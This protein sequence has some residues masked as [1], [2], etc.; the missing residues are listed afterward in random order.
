MAILQNTGVR[1]YSHE[2]TQWLKY[3]LNVLT[4]A[5][6]E[7]LFSTCAILAQYMDKCATCYPSQETI[8]RRLKKD[9][10]STN[11]HIKQLEKLQLLELHKPTRRKVIYTGLYYESDKVTRGGLAH[12]A[13][14]WFEQS[15]DILIENDKASGISVIFALACCM[16]KYNKCHPSQ[17]TI[18]KI[19]GK[20]KRTVVRYIKDLE[21][22]NIIEIKKKKFG[23]NLYSGILKNTDINKT[24]ETSI[25]GGEET[26]EH[27]HDAM[28]TYD[29]RPNATSDAL[30]RPK[31]IDYIKRKYC[32]NTVQVENYSHLMKKIEKLEKTNEKQKQENEK[33]N[34]KLDLILKLISDESTAK[35]YQNTPGGENH[36]E[37][38]S[39]SKTETK[40]KTLTTQPITPTENTTLQDE[41][42]SK[43]IIHLTDEAVKFY[44]LFEALTPSQQTELTKE[45]Q[46][47]N[48][49]FQERK[50]IISKKQHEE[51]TKQIEDIKQIIKIK[52]PEYKYF[53]KV[54]VSTYINGNNSLQ[55]EV[56]TS[57][58]KDVLNN[59]YYL[60]SYL[61]QKLGVAV[62][63]VY[64]NKTYSPA[65]PSTQTIHGVN[66]E[67]ERLSQLETVYNPK[68]KKHYLLTEEQQKTKTQ[69]MEY[70]EEMHENPTALIYGT[71]GTGKTMLLNALL[72][73]IAHASS[74]L[75]KSFYA[76]I[77]N[78][79]TLY[80]DYLTEDPASK[81]KFFDKVKKYHFL[82]IDEIPQ[83]FTDAE[84]KV[85]SDLITYRHENKQRTF[86]IS[87]HNYKELTKN[88]TSKELRT[89]LDRVK[90]FTL[91]TPSMRQTANLTAIRNIS[92]V[93]A[94]L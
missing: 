31:E 53:D 48:K 13:R 4:Q 56:N 2:V 16:D 71:N 11:K 63:I 33:I 5:K 10:R 42:Q 58:D 70:I 73:E 45:K 86:L 72:K 40:T 41:N 24:E 9:R 84:K 91:E 88:G 17:E 64:R 27:T 14:A 78:F 59:N 3:S 12:N 39:K 51:L 85:F 25:E 89:V 28:Y 6:K 21:D 65:L 76:K 47:A 92:T 57:F 74:L 67:I 75:D 93:N 15:T 60:Q 54:N 66:E 22:L 83:H 1:G 62:S 19:T 20:G 94:I 38:A 68:S 30:N 81:Y 43:E 69:L 8:A 34:Q 37:N 80:N 87:N 35:K 50:K 46:K 82:V 23:K 7:Y 18:V 52:N 77:L 79:R 29:D 44:N 26:Q 55:L 90:V 49:I 36:Q 61:M 32:N